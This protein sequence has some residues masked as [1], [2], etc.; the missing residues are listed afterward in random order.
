L[1]AFARPGLKLVSRT[2]FLGAQY[3][4]TINK[5]C[6][7]KSAYG[8]FHHAYLR[9]KTWEH[10]TVKLVSEKLRTNFRGVL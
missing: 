6:M 1:E 7:V 2:R 3:G 4:N 5:K 8:A 10:I 9:G